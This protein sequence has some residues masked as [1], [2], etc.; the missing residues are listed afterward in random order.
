MTATNVKDEEGGDIRE[1]LGFSAWVTG[2]LLLPMTVM[3]EAG[4]W[5]GKMN[6]IFENTGLHFST[7]DCARD[8]DLE[9]IC[10]R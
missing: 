3:R 8:V 4:F 1:K 5:E 9:T 7:E 6:L 10:K 2:S